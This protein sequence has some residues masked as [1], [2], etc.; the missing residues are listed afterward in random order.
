[1]NRIS[2]G[3]PAVVLLLSI[4]LFG[5]LPVTTRANPVPEGACCLPDQCRCEVLPQAWCVAYGG[6]YLGDQYYLCEPGICDQLLGACCI[7]E[8]CTLLCL[9]ECRGYGGEHILGA[10][11]DPNPCSLGACCLPNGHCNWIDQDPCLAQGGF[12]LGH[13]IE[14]YP[15]PCSAASPEPGGGDNENWGQIKQKYR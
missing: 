13:R 15:S 10:T 9:P 14:C 2:L 11:C 8:T 12:W 7:G 1:M 4:P 6:E 5:L 3:Y